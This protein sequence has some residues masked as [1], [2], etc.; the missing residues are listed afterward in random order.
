MWSIP[1]WAGKRSSSG[2]FAARITSMFPVWTTG[3]LSK[4]TSWYKYMEI[5]ANVAY[6]GTQVSSKGSQ[7]LEV[8][9][10]AGTT[11]SLKGGVLWEWS[12]RFEAVCGETRMV[13]AQTHIFERSETLVD[14]AGKLA[15]DLASEEEVSLEKWN[16]Q[17][18]TRCVKCTL[19]LEWRL[20]KSKE[21]ST[22]LSSLQGKGE[23]NTL[24]PD[25]QSEPRETLRGSKPNQTSVEE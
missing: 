11:A 7:L 5:L 9:Q 20:P 3:R 22:G 8:N 24:G 1:E 6:E 2:F 13:C 12:C 19:H 25:S 23:S 16:A 17:A 15:A 18:W 14:A 10:C 4:H 21:Q